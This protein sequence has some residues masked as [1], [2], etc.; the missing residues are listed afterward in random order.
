MLVLLVLSSRV[1][2]LYRAVSRRLAHLQ[3]KLPLN[4][5][6]TLEKKKVDKDGY[7][8]R[9]LNNHDEIVRFGSAMHA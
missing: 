1:F 3:S 7:V 5:L 9:Y 2:A 6:F 8:L 4:P